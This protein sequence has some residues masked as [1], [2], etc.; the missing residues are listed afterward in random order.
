MHL[1]SIN[2][3]QNALYLLESCPGHLSAQ[4]LLNDD[5]QIYV[6]YVPANTTALGQPM[7]QNVIC[8]IKTLYKKCLVNSIRVSEKPLENVIK[9]SPRRMLKDVICHQWKLGLRLP[10]EKDCGLYPYSQ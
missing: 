7:D 3:P 8:A 6:M 10:K 5:N 4:D 1:K 2:L 9:V